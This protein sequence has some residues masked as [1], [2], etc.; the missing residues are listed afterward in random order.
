MLMRKNVHIE[1]AIERMSKKH[2]GLS[3]ATLLRRWL[4]R[5]NC[6]IRQR[7]QQKIEEHKQQYIAAFAKHGWL[8]GRI[9]ELDIREWLEPTI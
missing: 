4:E 6:C 9:E 1:K 5:R 7:V 2:S 3:E 8:E